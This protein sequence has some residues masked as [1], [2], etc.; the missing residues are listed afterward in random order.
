VTEEKAHSL[1]KEARNFA[2]SCQRKLL[3]KQI[4]ELE[5]KL[6]NTGQL[7]DPN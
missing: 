3:L 2:G 4:Q 7:E 6:E 1:L 5:G